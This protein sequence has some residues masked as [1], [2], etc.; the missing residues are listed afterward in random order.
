[1]LMAGH[2]RA[3]QSAAGVTGVLV[4]AV[5]DEPLPYATVTIGDSGQ[6][7]F[8]NDGGR[9]S[10]TGLAAGLYKIRARQ[11][12]FSPFDTTITVGDALVHVV[13]RL[14]P[15]ALRLATVPVAGR[16]LRE[17]VMTGIPDSA[18]NPQ[19]AAIFS[20]LRTNVERYRLLLDQYPFHYSREEHE[21][22]R[23]EGGHDSTET[24]DTVSYYSR[25]R[26]PYRVGGV[27]YDE[28]SLGG[29]RQQKMYIPTFR[30]LAD[31][32]FQGAH[33][34]SYA[35]QDHGSIRI[36]FQPATR[37][38]A[39]DIEGSVYLDAH[40]YMV[41][42]AVF[43][44]TNPDAVVPPIHGLT[45]TTT[46]AEIVPLVSV[47][48]STHT[49]QPISPVRLRA[50]GLD[51]SSGGDYSLASRTAIEDDRLLDHTF[52]GEGLNTPIDSER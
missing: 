52:D 9:F 26:R 6:G 45:V 18:A 50:S 5:G 51:P 15:L 20:Q 24:L 38:K 36:H 17:C 32:A 13:F 7:R 33:C 14:Q 8:T 41:Q 12:G 2:V 1:V 49:E 35:G 43:R 22:V 29:S 42:R 46:F 37:I 11:I 10:L 47:V 4:S 31:P 16:R 44:M 48:G 40:R 34:F 3:Q 27:V 30:D 39:P 21:F 28:M 25:D 19:L 23:T